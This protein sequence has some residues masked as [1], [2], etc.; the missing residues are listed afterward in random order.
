MDYELIELESGEWII[1]DPDDC[2]LKT[3]EN[4]S[5]ALDNVHDYVYGDTGTENFRLHLTDISK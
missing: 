1:C 4:E 5:I 2:V 3:V